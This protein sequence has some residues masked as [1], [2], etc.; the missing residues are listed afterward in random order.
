MVKGII[1]RDGKYPVKVAKGW[2]YH[3]MKD[4]TRNFK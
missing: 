3:K 1:E 4:I 2:N